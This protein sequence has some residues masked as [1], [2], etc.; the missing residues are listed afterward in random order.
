[1]AEIRR[2]LFAE[3]ILPLALP[4]SLTYRVPFEWNDHVMIG[5]RVIVQLGKSKLYT[6]IIRQIG[7]S[8]PSGYEAKY[9]DGLLDNQP[10]VTA[11]QIIFWDWIAQY[12]CCT[13]GEV[14]NAA[15]PGGLKLSSETKFVIAEE[16]WREDATLSDRESEILTALEEKPCTI[17]DLSE[18]LGLRSVHPILKGLVEKELIYSE[19]ELRERFKPKKEEIL[20]LHERYLDE[21]EL[22]E[23]FILLEKP[24]TQKQSNALLYFLSLAGYDRGDIKPVPKKALLG[25]E[26]ISSSSVKSLIEKHVLTVESRE[27][28]PIVTKGSIAELPVLAANQE[29][30]LDET[31]LALEKYPV[32]L[33]HGVTSSGKTEIYCHLIAR[34]LS[35]KKQ[36]LFLLP[37][38]ALTTQLINR[39]R[40]YFGELVKIYHSGF[41]DNQ[42]SETWLNLLNASPDE[43][44][45]I[46]G[47]RSSLFL[48]FTKPGLIIIDEEHEQSFKQHDPSPRYHARDA[49]IV[50]AQKFGAK[51][52]LGS[53][54]PAIETYWNATH[55]RYGLVELHERFGGIELPEIIIAD[56][57]V[58]LKRKTMKGNFTTLLAEAMKEAIGQGE[59]IILFQNRRG[60]SPLWQCQSCGWVPMCTRCDVSMTYHKQ[61]H[62]LKCHYCGYATEPPQA[63]GACGHHELRM[64]G[65]G[66]EKIEEEVKE[67]FPGIG[68]QR[69]DLD[70]TRS[71]TSYQRIIS[72]FESGEIQVLVGTQMVTKG[73][74][75]DRVSVVGILNADRMMNYPDFRSMERSYQLMMQVAGRAGRRQKRGKVYVQTFTPD[76]WLLDMVKQ[77]NYKEL[78]VREV[79]ERHRFGYPP[80]TRM[81]RITVKHKEDDTAE[82]AAQE[83]VKQVLALH[84]GQVL[85]PEKPH[86]QRINNYFLRQIIIK[87][88]RNPDLALTKSLIVQ[89]GRALQQQTAF[90][91]VRLTIDVDPL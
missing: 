84:P 42:R 31:I 82:I 24:R 73:L 14:M 8:P 48:P 62:Q 69:M 60:Y 39:L 33:L 53:A 90:K 80:F 78:Y 11:T 7:E 17:H 45:I 76:H 19:E 21:K 58:D 61:V 2:T 27:L 16:N 29:R 89:A 13:V 51:V 12:Y 46:M 66:T 23:L 37:E 1:M 64:V 57:R 38:I 86:V 36:V 34:A 32:T 25:N 68:V 35:E 77:G 18:I 56:I 44:V 63:C 50:W 6:A 55:D 22:R 4:K 30:A 72:E 79:A 87:L 88:Y 52:V 43:P 15:L 40:K 5:Q 83:L 26:S 47:A 74:D 67:L 85:G 75:F 71:K 54:T 81:I 9:I 10:V 28:N 3:V 59:Q 41:S 91:S 49:A 70:T 20:H 65:F